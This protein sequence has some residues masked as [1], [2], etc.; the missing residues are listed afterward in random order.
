MEDKDL[1]KYSRAAAKLAIAYDCTTLSQPEVVDLIFTVGP[2][3]AA[4]PSYF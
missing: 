1:L 3:L 2:I 4:T